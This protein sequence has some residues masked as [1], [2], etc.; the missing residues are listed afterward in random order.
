M[1][2]QLGI[3]N[4]LSVLPLRLFFKSLQSNQPLEV[5][6]TNAVNVNRSVELR[7]LQN[8]VE[9]VVVDA[10]ILVAKSKYLIL[11]DSF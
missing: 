7:C 2:E 3:M 9:K 10:D 8:I 11:F 5:T 1:S 6:I 4:I